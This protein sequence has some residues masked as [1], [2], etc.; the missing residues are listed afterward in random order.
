MSFITMALI[1]GRFIIVATN[2]NGLKK[3]R[4]LS[5]PPRELA[6]VIRGL[7]SSLQGCTDQ[8]WDIES[9]LPACPDQMPNE[10]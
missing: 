1:G 5:V 7:R 10:P 9:A 4:F 6:T 2:V 3:A 8:V